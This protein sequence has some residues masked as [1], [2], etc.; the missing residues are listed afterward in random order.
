MNSVRMVS[1]TRTLVQGLLASFFSK[2]DVMGL[3]AAS[4]H[5]VHGPVAVALEEGLP[6]GVIKRVALSLLK[7]LV[8]LCKF[9]DDVDL[10]LEV[11]RACEGMVEAYLR[12]LEEVDARASSELF[13][14][15][16]DTI[17]EDERAEVELED[18][19]DD[20]TFWELGKATTLE[21]AA[22]RA[23]G[24]LDCDDEA[25]KER[26]ATVELSEKVSGSLGRVY[27]VWHTIWRR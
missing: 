19:I 4:T 17:E 13:E 23:F 5:P 11:V 8:N 2:V 27:D 22:S 12:V 24:A 18:G 15:V 9:K 1:V 26:V 10:W 6:E 14:G 7:D 21:E 3:Y 16:E 25:D 20:G